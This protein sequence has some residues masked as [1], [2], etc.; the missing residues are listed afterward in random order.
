MHEVE[1]A[2]TLPEVGRH[3]SLE[4]LRPGDPRYVD[5]TE[6]HGSNQIRQMQVCLQDVD[7]S[8]NH[9]GKIAFTG[10]RGCGKST[11][12]YRLESRLAER[13]TTLHL[14]V[15]DSLIEDVDYPELLLW[16]TDEALPDLDQGE[17]S[18]VADWFAEQTFEDVSTI[19]SELEANAQ[20]GGGALG[21]G[22]QLLARVKS[23][24]RASVDPR[25]TTRRKLQSYSAEPLQRVNG[26]LGHASDRLRRPGR[27]P[28]VLI[29]QDNTDRLPGDVARTVFCEHGEL[30]KRIDAHMILTVPVAIVLAPWNVGAVFENTFN[31][32]MVKPRH[33]DDSRNDAA[34]ARLGEVIRKRVEV[35]SVF[36]RQHLVADLA[37]ACGGSVRELLRLLN[38]AQL[39][40]R[41]NERTRIDE[42]SVDAAIGRL[43]TDFEK[44]L[45]PASAYF[46]LLARS[47]RMKSDGIEMTPEA[48]AAEVDRRRNFFGRL[49]F[50]GAVLEYN[51]KETWYDVPR[52]ETDQGVPTCPRTVRPGWT[53]R[54]S[55]SS[56][57][58]ASYGGCSCRSNLSANFAWS[59]R[60]STSRSFETGS[61][62]SSATRTANVSFRSRPSASKRRIP[63]RIS[64]AGSQNR[65]SGA[66]P[67]ARVL[68]L[69]TWLDY[70]NPDSGAWRRSTVSISTASASRRSAPV[71]SSSG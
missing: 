51:G 44:V 31:M 3:A 36:D 39:E 19:R 40:S 16:L 61:P 21:I 35:A 45:V 7:A 57:S 26:L 59:S 5:V 60:P 49:L 48:D 2:A 65:V 50:S 4:P 8:E 22:A 17:V 55:S 67:P 63:S 68:G 56:A 37:D 29:V 14:F 47:H 20:A 58:G 11:E 38:Y 10:H 46:P 27:P 15:D 6:G 32:P 23:A 28:D 12:L 53:V 18:R 69:E 30:F 13:F 71:R 66:P 62:A 9:Y 43:R 70:L 64:S 41:T 25:R 52:R 1:R 24:I 33:R 34:I 42:S 54:A